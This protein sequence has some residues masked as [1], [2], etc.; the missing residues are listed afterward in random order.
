VPSAY[1]ITVGGKKLIGSAQ[2]RRREGVLQHGSLPLVGD[3]ARITE[4]LAFAEEAARKLAAE[5]LLARATTV[6]NALGR[7]VSWDEAAAAFVR[8][9]ESELGL[10]FEQ[11]ELSDAEARRA[12][13][14]VAQKYAH[15]D[16]MQRV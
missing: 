8:S 14:L 5:R 4:V 6:Q 1:E 16:W 7:V 9:F 10:H 2:A 11:A 3:L 13:E 12:A 15:P